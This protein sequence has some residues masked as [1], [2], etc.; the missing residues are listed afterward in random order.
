MPTATIPWFH[1]LTDSIA[2][3]GA[4]AREYRTASQSAR[5]AVW[6][7]EPLRLLPV[8]GAISVPGRDFVRAH[9]DATLK[10][11]NLYGELER[12][13]AS[14]YEN[15]ALAYAYGTAHALLA[16]LR[17]ERPS[18]LE[19]D[20][21]DGEY[22]RPT[23]PLPDFNDVVE[24]WTSKPDLAALRERVIEGE[25]ARSSVDDLAFYEDLAGYETPTIADLRDRAAGLADSAYAYGE[26]AERILY[27]LLTTV[28]THHTTSEDEL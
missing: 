10:I 5:I 22:V 23:A 19:F 18:Y 15:A 17:G 27:Y 28:R 26:A 6:H 9:D 2:A 24:Q 8:D 25:R 21:R 20:R 16:V 14:L 13:T 11:S 12:A 4:A 1:S 7:F 3:L